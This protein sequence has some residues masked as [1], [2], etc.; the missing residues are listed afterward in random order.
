[1]LSYAERVII[2]NITATAKAA[3]SSSSEGGPPSKKRKYTKRKPSSAVVG[4]QTEAT[5]LPTNE[6]SGGAG[7]YLNTFA[8]IFS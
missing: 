2:E 1:M 8:K 3:T 7:D 6:S 5:D 4:E